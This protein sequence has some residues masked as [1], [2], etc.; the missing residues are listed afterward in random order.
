ML[1]K[2]DLSRYRSDISA[3]AEEQFFI[4]ETRRPIVLEPH[5]KRIL[6]DIFTVDGD[7]RFPY[8]TIVYSAPKKS[9]KT[10]ISALIALWFALTQEAPNEIYCCANDFEQSVGRV[11]KTICTAIRL[12]P[13]L[14]SAVTITKNEILFKATGT[15]IT[16]LPSDY[17]GAA[18]SNHGLTCWDELWGY[19][20][21]SSRRLWDELTPVPTRKNSLR[22]VTT[23]AGWEGESDLLWELYRQGMKGKPLYAD[24]PVKTDGRLYFYWDH[25]PRMPWQI[26]AYYNQQRKDL[27]PNAYLRLHENQWTTNEEAFIDLEW[28]DSSIDKEH[29]PLL[30]SD[31]PLFVAVDAA[32]KRDSAAVVATY[33]DF[34]KS[35]VVLARHRI[36]QPT[37]SEPLDLENTMEAYLLSMYENYPLAVVRYDPFQFHRSAMTLKTNGL[38]MEEFAQT[39][40]NLTAMGQNLFELIKHQNIVLYADEELR[41][42]ASQAVAIESSRGWRIAKE[43]TS[44]KID[45]IVALA[46]SALAAVPSE[47]YGPVIEYEIPPPTEEERERLEA[48][49]LG[50]QDNLSDGPF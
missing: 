31:T 40:S 4:P 48:W 21:E 23:Y 6:R 36:W 45:V 7:G 44:H 20:S 34:G 26:S 42:A 30:T 24:L 47:A 14:R 28:W 15:S 25:T 17:A 37:P 35:K 16:A 38:P 1:S 19:I 11:F 18:G 10:T 9:G 3:F 29:H 49:G 46:M 50:H 5:Q 2:S 32:V 12:N 22:L 27:R 33:F 13:Y 39:V 8:E 43:K 41:K